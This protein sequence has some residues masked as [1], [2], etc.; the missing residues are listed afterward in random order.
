MSK[1]YDNE[2]SHKWVCKECYSEAIVDVWWYA[3]N[4]TPMCGECDIDM[5]PF[6]F[7]EEK[8]SESE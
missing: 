8:E 2:A 3:G 4:G 5:E 7:E 1:E 6:E